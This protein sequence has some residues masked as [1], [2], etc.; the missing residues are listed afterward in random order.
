MTSEPPTQTIHRLPSELLAHIFIL[1]LRNIQNPHKN[2]AWMN[3]S[4]PRIPQW[5]NAMFLSRNSEGP[6]LP[7]MQLWILVHH[8]PSRTSHIYTVMARLRWIRQDLAQ[9]LTC[10]SRIVRS[11]GI[12][13]S[14]HM[15]SK[16]TSQGDSFQSYLKGRHA[17]SK[18]TLPDQ[19]STSP[20]FLRPH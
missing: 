9:Y 1:S 7:F 13:L 4:S 3:V 15:L 5:E 19:T 8:S 2:K 11:G 20:N 17:F 10:Y 12:Y 6:D 16:P 14:M 18:Y